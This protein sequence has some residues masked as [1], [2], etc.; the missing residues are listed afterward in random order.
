MKDKRTKIMGLNRRI[1]ST[2]KPHES[3]YITYQV[4]IKVHY[5]RNRNTFAFLK[6]LT[7]Q[8]VIGAG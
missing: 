2:E 6:S 5:G 3:N 1:D 7:A 8:N 4:T